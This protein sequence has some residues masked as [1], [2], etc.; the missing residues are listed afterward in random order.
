MGLVGAA[1]RARE[2]IEGVGDA[3]LGE[4]DERGEI[5]YHIRRRLTPEEQLNVGPA[6]DIRGGREA[7]ERLTRAWKYLPVN[8]RGF[9]RREIEQAL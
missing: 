4:W 9:A 5:A 3:G 6:C 7:Q 8:L 1:V 2:V